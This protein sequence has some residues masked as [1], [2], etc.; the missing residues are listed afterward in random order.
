[1]SPSHWIASLAVTAAL[2]LGAGL[3]QTT[4]E[5]GATREQLKTA[6]AAAQRTEKASVFRERKRAA[7]GSAAASAA[8]SLDRAIEAQQPWADQPVPQEIQDA[9]AS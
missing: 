4:K 9:L 6:Q 1:M 8:H 2:L 5:L 7:T 3:Y